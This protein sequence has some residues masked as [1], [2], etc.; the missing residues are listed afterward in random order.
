[1]SDSPSTFQGEPGGPHGVEWNDSAEL[2]KREDGG[3]VLHRFKTVRRGT[4]AELIRFVMNHPEA[5]RADYVIEKSGDHRLT[6]GEIAALARR[7]D[8]P[9]E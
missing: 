1:M 3:G 6:P 8:F 4:L 5:E 9:K 7:D 2:H